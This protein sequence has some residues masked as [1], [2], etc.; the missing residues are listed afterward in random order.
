MP[1]RT[2]QITTEGIL[3]LRLSERVALEMI[4]AA[5]WPLGTNER[6]RFAA[7]NAYRQRR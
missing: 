4:T 6:I 2:H 5:L 1:H 7:D 3:S